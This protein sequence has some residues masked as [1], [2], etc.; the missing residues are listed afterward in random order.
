M[1]RCLPRAPGFVLSLLV[2]AAPVHAVPWIGS[3][4]D[5][6]NLTSSWSGG[7][8]P[9][10]SNSTADFSGD[11]GTVIIQVIHSVGTFH[12]GPT[13]TSGGFSIRNGGSLAL[14]NGIVNDSSVSPAFSVRDGTLFFTGNAPQL[15][16]ANITVESAGLLKLFTATNP[17]GSAARVN[18]A[19]G[20]IGVNNVTDGGSVSLGELKGTGGTVGLSS[21][22]L[23]VGALGTDATFS[24]TIATVASL[25]K[26]GAGTWTLTG[27]NTYTGSTLISGGTIRINNS[28]GSAFG[29]GNVT[30]GT[31]G[32]LTGAGSFTGA[33][34]N[35][36]T[37]APGNSP[38]LATLSSFS[39]GSSGTLTL[40]IGGLARGTGYD[41]LDITGSAAFG[42]TLAVGFYGGFSGADLSVGNTFN[43]FNW[44]SVSGTF[45][46][47]NLADLSAYGLAWDISAL[48]SA[49]EIT[50]IAASAVPEPSTYAALAGLA[51]LGAAMVR[52]RR[53]R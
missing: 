6:F 17:N 23:T 46:T 30:I 36:G 21:A 1:K 25:T 32:T 14:I 45:D 16:N 51:A 8:V 50:V 18:L 35:N 15:G 48:Y 41:A 9:S 49:G 38:T 42:G 31:A 27:A 12:F 5:A 47:L 13:Y 7:V 3:S 24:G 40:E 43:F 44:G 52:R 10:G 11:T 39:Q 53:A 29:T 26:V 34:Q 20:R 4:G 22:A 33:L 2:T 19:G 28:T 37:Y